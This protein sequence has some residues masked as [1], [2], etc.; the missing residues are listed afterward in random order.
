MDKTLK[1]LVLM[2]LL[3][4]FAWAGDCVTSPPQTIGGSVVCHGENSATGID[5][6][7]NGSYNESVTISPTTGYAVIAFAY[8]CFDG[9]QA[10][11]INPSNW[12]ASH[13]Y[14]GCSTVANLA[15]CTILPTSNNPCGLVFYAT[16]SGT[17]GSGGSEPTWSSAGACDSTMTIGDNTVI[18]TPIQLIMSDN[19]SSPE[20]CFAASPQ[21]PAALQ[22]AASSNYFN[23][24]FYCPSIQ[25]GVTSVTA[26][27]NVTI[28]ST[29]SPCS[30]ISLFVGYYSG[31]CTPA[32]CFDTGGL[33]N[34]ANCT[35]LTASTSA[36]TRYTNELVIGIGG[37]VKDEALTATN[38]CVQIDQEWVGNQILGKYVTNPGTETC[39][40]SWTG[41]DT[42]GLLLAAI[43][44]AA[45]A[46]APIHRSPPMGVMR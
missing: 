34:C 1:F 16:T 14:S 5:G 35:S 41:R 22:V 45:S 15:S 29:Y 46:P 3:S 33:G 43:K 37:T 2:L 23:Y 10:N 8:A 13:P 39:G 31:M 18:W 24:A 30:Y 20:T 26:T 40:I 7:K 6:G 36:S 9:G 12:A 28:S 32:P 4:G 25:S 44:S 19:Q 11:C 38:A 17:S 21:S 27:C 42:G